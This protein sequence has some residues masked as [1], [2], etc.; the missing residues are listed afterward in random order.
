[1]GIM[2]WRGEVVAGAGL[3]A[4]RLMGSIGDRA[5]LGKLV[6]LNDW[7]QYTVTARGGTF[8]HLVNGQLM[9]VMVDDD[10]ESSNNQAGIFGIEIEV[11]TKVSV[12]NIWPKKLD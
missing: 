9:A 3:G 2:A 6:K 4:K 7:N 10:P 11:A 1:M 5:E 8:L 12:R